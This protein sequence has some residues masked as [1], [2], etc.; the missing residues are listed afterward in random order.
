M[1]DRE[2]I[3]LGDATYACCEH[4]IMGDRERRLREERKLRGEN[5]KVAEK[6]CPECGK[7]RCVPAD[8]ENHWVCCVCETVFIVYVK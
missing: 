5:V 7:K 2:R 8:E 4:G 6:Y 3:L 1:T